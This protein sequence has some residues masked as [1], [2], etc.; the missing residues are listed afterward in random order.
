MP[1]EQLTLPVPLHNVNALCVCT[2]DAHVWTQQFLQRVNSLQL[3]PLEPRL[4]IIELLLLKSLPHLTTDVPADDWPNT[5]DQVHSILPRVD[6]RAQKPTEGQ[7]A[8]EF[9]PESLDC[10]GDAI[11]LTQDIRYRRTIPFQIRPAWIA[12]NLLMLVRYVVVLYAIF[13]FWRVVE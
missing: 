13:C 4:Y 9:K 10:E 6:T 1:N 3:P 7:R 8:A 11:S 5:L 12:V 2:I